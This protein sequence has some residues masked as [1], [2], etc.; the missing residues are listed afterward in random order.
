MLAVVPTPDAVLRQ[1]GIVHSAYLMLSHIV[2]HDMLCRYRLLRR[3]PAPL[4]LWRGLADFGCCIVVA[5]SVAY[6]R[7][8]STG[9]VN[10]ISHCKSLS[11]FN[12]FF[13]VAAEGYFLFLTVDLKVAITN[14]FNDFRILSQWCVAPVMLHPARSTLLV[15]WMHTPLWR[16]GTTWQCWY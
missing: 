2:S 7:L 12:E 11:F 1:F 4:L 6:R 8:Y 14:P 15:M 5:T 16:A 13:S 10:D 3:H 9:P